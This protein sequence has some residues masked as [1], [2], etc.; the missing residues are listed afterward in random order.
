VID[1]STLGQDPQEPGAGLGL[2]VAGSEG[3]SRSQRR[4]KSLVEAGANA[5][6]VRV[7]GV[8]GAHCE[9]ERFSSLWVSLLIDDDLWMHLLSTLAIHPIY[10]SIYRAR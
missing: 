7:A 4:K 8:G 9:M 5:G 10:P 1:P 3:G 6:A 2:A